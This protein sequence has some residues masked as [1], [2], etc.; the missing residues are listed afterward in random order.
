MVHAPK[1]EGEILAN[2]RPAR[3]ENPPRA[4]LARTPT[5]WCFAQKA[6]V[7]RR[8]TH[9]GSQT[10]TNCD[11]AQNR[12]RRHLPTFFLCKRYLAAL[13]DSKPAA[14]CDRGAC[15]APR[16]QL[17]VNSP[18]SFV[19]IPSHADHAQG[20]RSDHPNGPC[21][22]LRHRCRT[23]SGAERSTATGGF[24]EISPPVIVP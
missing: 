2:D 15:P 12:R 4:S 22:R 14:V 16:P 11:G 1:R 3:S 19:L 8:L 9:A 5:S 23:G 24:A 18:Q 20:H 6:F 10:T 13:L 21:G 7:G 17:E